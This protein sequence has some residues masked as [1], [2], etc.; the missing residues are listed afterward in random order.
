[1]GAYVGTYE[2]FW[3][4]EYTKER[5][6]SMQRVAEVCKEPRVT[7][8][9]GVAIK[10]RVKIRVRDMIRVSVG[11]YFKVMCSFLPYIMMHLGEEAVPPLTITLTSN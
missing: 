11:V 5:L 1:M 6:V 10:N 8:R 4:H 3:S 7:V 2:V 9:V